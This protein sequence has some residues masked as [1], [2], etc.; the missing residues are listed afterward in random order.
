MKALGTIQ[1]WAY[2][3]HDSTNHKY[4]DKPYSYHLKQVEKWGTKFQHL[5]Y[6]YDMSLVKAILC[7]LP[8]HDLI[9]DVR[10]T[11]N[12]VFKFTR[13]KLTADVVY[14]VTNEKGKTRAD[15]ANSKYYRGIRW[16]HGATFVKLC[17]RLANVEESVKSGKMLDKYRKEYPKFKAD[18]TLTWYE[19]V[20]FWLNKRP[21]IDY[22]P[23][24][25]E[26]E[27]MLNIK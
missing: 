5:L 23:M 7:A 2:D 13:S 21:I 26:L 12:D 14:A 3:L 18:L 4:G 20:W 6:V 17:D 10:V 9:E 1:E 11:W 24:F 8:C 27:K 16:T 22:T 15:R 19:K 25:N